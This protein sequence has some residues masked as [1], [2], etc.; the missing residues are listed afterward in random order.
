MIKFDA[1]PIILGLIAGASL[2]D[3]FYPASNLI[4]ISACITY[5]LIRLIMKKRGQG[6]W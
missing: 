2:A 5:G 4:I 6:H 3:G 1:I